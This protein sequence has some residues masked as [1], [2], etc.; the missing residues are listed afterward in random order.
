MIGNLLI[1]ILS[2]AL[3]LLV[4]AGGGFLTFTLTTSNEELMKDWNDVVQA[5]WFPGMHAE[6]PESGEQ[7]PEGGEQ[8]PESGEQTPESGEQTPEG[9]EQ[10]PESGEQTPEGNATV[11][12]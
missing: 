1:R 6:A 2:F 10:A 12:E 8:T 4:L 3:C 11:T 7:T 9:G 5:E